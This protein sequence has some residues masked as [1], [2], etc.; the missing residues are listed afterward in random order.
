MSAMVDEIEQARSEIRDV[1]DG[2][3]TRRDQ[4]LGQPATTSIA[5][6]QRR[7]RRSHLAFYALTTIMGLALCALGLASASWPW[8]APTQPFLGMQVEAH[9]WHGAQFAALL[10]I[11]L[12][13][14]LLTL[15]W[16]PRRT[17]LLAQYLIASSSIMTALFAVFL[18]PVALTLA[19]PFAAVAALY[20]D[21]AALFDLNS[22][23]RWSR[24]LGA[25]S[26]ITAAL[27]I[28]PTYVALSYQILYP[29]SE[30]SEHFHWV[31]AA[32]LAVALALGGLLAATRGPGWRI[33]AALV[34]IAYVYLGLAAVA[35]PAH[36]GSW[37]VS[38]GIV[39]AVAGALYIALALIPGRQLEWYESGVRR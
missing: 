14:S 12:G 29:H 9:R 1:T 7:A 30:H 38:G 17:P 13:G 18:G 31:A 35:V 27:L 19:A 10:A 36:A 11:L 6:A 16:R 25:L 8:Y 22:H 33:L 37:G 4:P 15:I 26:L 32:A 3:R 24:P 21:R 20:P 23:E 2:L 28:Q 34:G 5:A 39:A